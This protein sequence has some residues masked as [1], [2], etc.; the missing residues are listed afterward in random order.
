MQCVPRLLL[1]RCS[2]DPF[3]HDLA[4]YSGRH[5]P[6]A[7]RSKRWGGTEMPDTRRRPVPCCLA[8]VEAKARNRVSCETPRPFV[9]ALASCGMTRESPTE[10]ERLGH[11]GSV[12]FPLLFDPALSPCR[13]G[14]ASSCRRGLLPV[15]WPRPRPHCRCWLSPRE[16]PAGPKTPHRLEL[17]RPLSCLAPRG[18][19][20][21]KTLPNRIVQPSRA[22]IV[23]VGSAPAHL[24]LSSRQSRGV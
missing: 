13:V 7:T 17:P 1:T 12:S 16:L 10:Q 9:S 21:P 11:L 8:F 22:L 19:L 18:D 3:L 4:P 14:F 15:G 2:V 6:G 24:T 20:P 5:I 23:V